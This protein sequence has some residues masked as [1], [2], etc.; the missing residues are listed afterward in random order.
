MGGAH[1]GPG[2]EDRQEVGN[3]RY[4]GW[5]LSCQCNAGFP[6]GRGGK[7]HRNLP[8]VRRKPTQQV[9]RVLGVGV[10]GGEVLPEGNGGERQR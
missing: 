2:A 3:R 1:V 9:T 6:A 4:L 5:S 8:N 7:S 10:C